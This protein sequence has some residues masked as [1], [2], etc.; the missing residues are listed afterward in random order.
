MPLVLLL[1]GC[2]LRIGR[3]FG[4]SDRCGRRRGLPGSFLR[5]H[6]IRLGIDRLSSRIGAIF[7][8]VVRCLSRLIGPWLFT[9][10]GLVLRFLVAGL[11]RFRIMQGGFRVLVLFR[12]LRLLGPRLLRLRS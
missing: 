10:V 5:Q 3:G 12:V 7:G 9:S 8:C 1:F 2:G 11:G 4:F 6:G